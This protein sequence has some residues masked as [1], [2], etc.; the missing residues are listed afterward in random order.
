MKAAIVGDLEIQ[1]N[2]LQTLVKKGDDQIT[3]LEKNV[4]TLELQCDDLE[5][6]SR[7]NSLR[8]EGIPERKDEDLVSTVMGVLDAMNLEPVV[9][10][11]S[12]NRAHRLGIYIPI[13]NLLY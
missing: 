9:T 1:I 5:Q 12:I 13:L 11:D 10:I 3:T 8:I 6:Y 7:R 4:A 2:R